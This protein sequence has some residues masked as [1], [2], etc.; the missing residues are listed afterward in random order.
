L[1]VSAAIPNNNTPDTPNTPEVPNAKAVSPT[2]AGIAVCPILF[3]LNRSA[4]QV[5]AVAGGTD[6]II[7]VMVR[8]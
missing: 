7:I 1:E 6:K 5:F 4:N 3:A 2:V 8:G